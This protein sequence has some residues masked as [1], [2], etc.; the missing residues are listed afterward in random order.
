[1]HPGACHCGA[2][3]FELS[4]S[5]EKLVDCNCS[6]C[7]R[8]AALWGHVPIS[9]VTVKSEPEA[10]IAYI[11]GDKML[12][13]HTCKNCGCT[14]H[15]SSLTDDGEHMAVNFRMCEP[16]DVANFQIKK[17]DG[18]NTWQFLD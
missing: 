4:E 13:F 3:K 2:V 12:A 10:T 9:A 18:A 7:R 15:W 17:F 11:H 14:T 1:M 6:I 8:L 5:P 16:E